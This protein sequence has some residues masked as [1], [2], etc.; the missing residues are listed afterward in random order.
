VSP[1][2][3]NE[4]LIPQMSIPEYKI[5]SEENGVQLEWM[6]LI[7][8]IHKIKGSRFNTNDVVDKVV[9]NGQRARNKMNRMH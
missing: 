1:Y 5:D 4:K 6:V 8:A 2:I 3:L 7:R 9:D